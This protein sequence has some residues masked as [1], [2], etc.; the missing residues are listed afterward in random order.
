[1]TKTLSLAAGISAAALLLASPSLAQPQGTI[2]EYSDVTVEGSILEPEP[3]TVSDDAELAGLIRVPEGFAVEVVARDFGNTRMLA[4][5][6]D[7][8]YASRRTEADIIRLDDEDGDGKYESFTTVAARPGMHGIA[9]HGDTAYLATVNE[10]YTAPVNE[11]GS[12]GEL[13]QIINDL[14]DG[15]QHANRTL[16]IGPDD[17]LYITVGSTC[18][19]CQ[20]TNPESATI[21]RASLDGKSRTI[22]ASGLRNTIGFGWEPSSGALYGAD[23]GTDWLGDEEQKEEFNLIEQG[24]KYGWPYVFDFGNFN[25]HMNPPMG[26][27]LEQWAA[28]SEEPALGYTAH[29]APM[30]MTFYTGTAFPE[31]YRGDAFIAMRGSWNRRPP[32]GYEITRVDF[33]DGQPATWDH[34][35]EGLLVEHED[36]NYG[37]LGRL[38]GITET[39]DGTLLFA[40]DFNG[41]IY[42]ISHEGGDN[43]TAAEAADVPDVTVKP[44]AS[45]IAINLVETEGILEVT[46]PSFGNGE[47]VPLKHAAQGDNASPALEWGTP[48][49]GTQSFLVIADDPDAVEPKPFVHWVLFDIPGDATGVG[50]GLAADPV[51]QKPENAKHGTNSAGKLGYMGPR[52]PLED[53]AHNYHFQVFAL[54]LS[55]LP[56]DPGAT[57]EDV[58]AA[59][60]GH[61]I[62]KGEV[63][64]TYERPGPEKPIN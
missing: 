51:L 35:A 34:F 38:A 31:E 24:Q 30:Q 14:P 4:T 41:I 40:D 52:P 33:E 5:H 39:S 17:M 42:R 36:G 53:P 27:T 2:G 37:F 15:G 50:E 26:V 13:K 9:F 32:S 21:L 61:V 58:L 57:R 63:V 20:E 62:A 44:P 1:M 45:D 22:F 43:G 12:F 54:D 25:P 47:L 8:V 16:A 28:Q 56:V 64:G 49:E 11:D 3:V 60:E 6:G 10:V 7:H 23:H 55:Q 29:A 46:A 19:E 18:N 59:I 48:P